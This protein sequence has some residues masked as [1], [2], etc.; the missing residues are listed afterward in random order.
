MSEIS[1]E[2]TQHIDRIALHPIFGLPIFF[3]IMLLTFTLTFE[4]AKPFTGIIN[5]LLGEAAVVLADVLNSYGA[6][7][8]AVSLIRDG[9]FGGVG[10]VL[11][12]L[13]NIAILLFLV[14]FLEESGYT[15]RTAVLMNRFMKTMG[16][17]GKAFIPMAIGLGCNVPAIMATRSLKNPGERLLTIL[18]IP[19]MSCSARLTV[20]VLFVSAFFSSNQSAIIFLL[21]LIGIAMAI[22]MGKIFSGFII[23]KT[24]MP[25]SVELPHYRIPLLKS[26]I[27]HTGGSCRHFI[28]KAGT[29]IFLVVV[30]I[31]FFARFPFGVEYASQQSTIGRIGT[32]LE[33]VFAPLG[34]G[35][36]KASV[37]L[38]FGIIAKET[39]VG[40]IGALNGVEGAGIIDAVQS[41]FTPLSAFSF[42]VITLL[43]TPCIPALSV[44]RKETNSWKWPLFAAVYTFILAWCAAFLVYQTG[45]FLGFG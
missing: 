35:N 2:T 27:K 38:I 30:V 13:P 12:F 23:K 14:N 19:L 32:I 3:A 33:P 6:P 31:W 41:S 16:L 34:F 8:L 45:L 25:T 40:T 11:V 42:M 18:L 9:F 4:V 43:Y 20:Y 39:I 24:Y 26:L 5:W 1:C 29:V 22:I 37:S 44:I 15:A 28:S 36:Y 10:S 17:P 21:Y 7:E